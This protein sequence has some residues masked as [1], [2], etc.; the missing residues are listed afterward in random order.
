MVVAEEVRTR[1]QAVRE[2][3]AA[4]ARRAGRRPEDVTLVAVSKARPLETI[5]A[6]YAVGLRHFGE[7]RVQEAMAKFGEFHP[8]DLTLHL[9]G[10]LQ[11]NKAKQA[12]A[13]CDVLHSL[14]SARLAA[15]LAGHCARRSAPLPVLVEV[16]VA[17]E[18]SKF[19]VMPAEVL[20]LLRTVLTLPGLRP[21]G[22]MTIAPLVSDGEQTRPV[23]RRLR[24]LR[25]ECARAL[26][27]PLPEL[28][29]G[30]T[31]DFEVAVEEGATLVRVGR[32]LFGERG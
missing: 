27:V 31:N 26:G 3:I 24:E 16:N 4:A 11:S 25:D 5:E 10:H 14:D 29:M 6:A 15:V 13:F 23:F 21:V 20:P 2:R 18:E 17:G 12:A 30:M 22:L 9:I 1:V 7:N 8:P 32:A 28:S 19:G